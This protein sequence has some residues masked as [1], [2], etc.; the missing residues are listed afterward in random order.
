MYTHYTR[1][2]IILVDKKLLHS[3][4]EDSQGKK[5]FDNLITQQDMLHYLTKLHKSENS[6]RVDLFLSSTLM[7]SGR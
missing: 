1:I 6:L 3:R 2:K 5:Y 7:H 4:G